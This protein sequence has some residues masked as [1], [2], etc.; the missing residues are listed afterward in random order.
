MSFLQRKGKN[1]PLQIVTCLVAVL[2][3]GWLLQSCK[4]D[5]DLLRPDRLDSDVTWNPELAVPLIESEID[6]AEAL[7]R[8]D[9][10]D[11]VLWDAEG[12][13]AL[14]YFSEVFSL[15]AEDAFN[16]PD[17][18]LQPT[19]VPIAPND[20]ATVL[21]GNDATT[22]IPP[23]NFNLDLSTFNN[24]GQVSAPDLETVRF[25]NGSFNFSVSSGVSCDAVWTITFQELLD[26]GAPT[27]ITLNVPANGNNAVNT[28][29][30]GRVLDMSGNPNSLTVSA[31]VTYRTGTGAPVAG[32]S[33]QLTF[34]LAGM[35]FSLLT[36]DLNEQFVPV[37]LDTVD[38]RLFNNSDEGDI[39]W[40]EPRLVTIFTNSFGA[41]LL[42][43]TNTF[44]A[45]DE[46]ENEVVQI[47]SPFDAGV[48]VQGNP[49]QLGVQVT[50]DTLSDVANP[51]TNVVQAAEIEPNK[52]IYQVDLTAD[53]ASSAINPNWVADTSRLKMDLEAYLPFFGR[54]TNFTKTD[55]TEVDI[56]P[57]DDDI[58]EITSVQL[59]LIIEN[60]FPIDAVGQ[61]RFLDSNFVVI[62]SVWENGSEQIIRSGTVVNNQIDQVNGRTIEITDILLERELLER[63]ETAGLRHVEL[64]GSIETTR[65]GAQQT[66]VK[67]FN[68]YSLKLNLAMKVEAVVNT[69]NL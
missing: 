40:E 68:T 42:I 18:A 10:E 55:T 37:D 51:P 50:I 11:V 59:R 33:S 38:V 13:L 31:S 30:A 60:G 64:R 3:S 47:T 67:I 21:G 63:L 62:D 27:T 44:Y 54:A 24:N 41:D 66:P 14:K 65:D 36:G 46:D 35:E 19:A 52:L 26:N 5:Y 56:F 12:L 1:Q 17:Q 6:M 39:F 48:V 58:E 45:L 7:N 20:V 28:L 32:Q 8:F 16:I 29:L 25:K 23:F 53:P 4:K 57:I 34:A 49:N 15:T 9:D 61:I 69:G 2:V 43:Q 22:N